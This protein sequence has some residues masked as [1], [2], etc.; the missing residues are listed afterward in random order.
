MTALLT[1][2][3]P[4]L[5]G[6]P[7]G[8]KKLRELIL[9]LAV[10]GKL[11]PQDPSDEPASE[12][13][14]RIAE[15]KARLVAE[16]K[17]KKQKDLADAPAP[18]ITFPL[19]AGWAAT[20][21]GEATICRD[22]ER[23]PVSRAER[24][25]LDKVFDY[26]GASG[27]IDKIDDYLFDKPLLLVGE[28]GANLINRSTP[29]AFMA[30]GR[31]WV[32]NHAHVLDG[33]SEELLLYI[34]LHFNA[35]DLK[36]YVT[37][38]AQPKMN[39]AKMNGISVALPPEAEQHRIVAKVDELMV[40]C[41][42]LEAQQ[43]DA[44][45][46]HAQLVQALLNSLTQASNADD[47]AQSW[48]RLA[49]HFHTLFTTEPSIDALKQTLL[50]LAVMG[51]LVQQ[52][53]SEVSPSLQSL[54]TKEPKLVNKKFAP[55]PV[56]SGWDWIRLGDLLEEGR[57][58]SYGIIKLGTEP[59]QGGVPTL[60]CSDVKPGYID[61][62][63]VRRVAHDIEQQY[64]RTRLRGGEVLINIRGT[65][66][67]VAV[68]DKRL[69]GYNVAREVAVVPLNPELSA[70]YLS[71]AMQS[72]YF[73]QR[74]NEQLRGIA[75]KGLNLGALRL[76]PIPTPPVAEQ[77]RIVAKVDQLMALCDQL[78]AQIS[79][80]QQ[81]HA[82]LADA[83]IAE[84]LN[85]KTPANEHNASPREARALLGAE[86]LYALDGEQHTGRV[87]LQKIISLTEHAAKLQEIQSNEQRFAAGPHDPA[88]MREL[89]DEL[90]ARHW[91]AERL[92][93]NGKRYEYQP[94]SKAG[95]H[96]RAYQKLWSD[97]QRRCV[98]AILNLVHSWD[99]ARCE[100][101][102]TLYSAW[103]DLL[104]EGK[105]CSE[106]NILREVT[107]RWHDSKRQY[108]DSVWRSELQSMKQHTVLLPS[109]FGRRT[110][111]GTLTLPG[112]E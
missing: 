76:F 54:G 65:L 36:P 39:Q 6:A 15:E 110:T 11:V 18:V 103:N 109:G 48:Q 99:T 21:I 89:A 59:K 10:R 82:D 84:S 40:L 71:I 34:E 96:R 20:S 75:Y 3:L 43:A 88:L 57:D 33:V 56:P 49:E 50:Q 46:A 87:K 45:S 105:P 107:Q 79:Q 100:R 44:D 9:E 64:V 53:P 4:L 38:T 98:D 106:D 26:Y 104:I 108:T 31:Y 37:G 16:G 112:F 1:D 23:V 83:L 28:D 29:I 17:I 41:D 86:I 7:N 69:A 74:I 111:G 93:D 97:E 47:F 91:F 92:R 25:G 85:E 55:Y 94:L 60:R 22:G 58:I 24:E 95:E 52:D 51:K 66:G 90:E 62:R 27:V 35:I 19:P 81:L 14:K 102:S 67:G 32:N 8:I 2:N 12:L 72:S 13:L 70:Q 63:G 80:A 77:H 73:W 30:R 61:L 5:A 42:R 68:A 101:V 78:K